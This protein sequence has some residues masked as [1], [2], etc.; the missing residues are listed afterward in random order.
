[1]IRD[2]REAR[3]DLEL[4]GTLSVVIKLERILRGE[5]KDGQQKKDGAVCHERQS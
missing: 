1:M 4:K 3:M 2:N 5:I